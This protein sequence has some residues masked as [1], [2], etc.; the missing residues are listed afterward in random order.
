MQ[1]LKTKRHPV[2]AIITAV[3]LEKIA[4]HLALLA[5]LSIMFKANG[6]SD[7]GAPAIFSLAA[8]ACLLHLGAGWLKSSTRPGPRP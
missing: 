5:C 7:T 4:R 3:G 2:S 1:S 6:W 8:A